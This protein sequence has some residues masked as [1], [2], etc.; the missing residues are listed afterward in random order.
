MLA[1]IAATCAHC[2]AVKGAS[3][4]SGA[5]DIAD[6]DFGDAGDDGIGADSGSAPPPSGNGSNDGGDATVFAGGGK[7]QCSQATLIPLSGANPRVD[8]PSTTVGATHDVD[9]PCAAEQGP[10]IFYRFAV[11]KRAFIYADTFGATWDTVLFLLSDSCVPIPTTMS[12]GATCSDDGCGTKQSQLVALVEPGYYKLGLAG[13]GSATGAA[14]IHFEWALAGSGNVAQ[15][16]KMNSVQVGTTFGSGGNIDGISGDCL[17]AAAENS[18]WWA[19]CPSDPAQTL[20]ASTCAGGTTWE[21][22]LETQIPRSAPAK[23]SAYTCNVN[24]CGLQST[25]T[26]SIPAGAGLGV[27]SIDGQ[28]GN[29][30]GPYTMTVTYTP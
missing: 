21:S 3:G 29:D 14:T 11:S 30:V 9:A 7:D 20:N 23:P 27:L 22:V 12:G 1:L 4:G 26:T 18:Y 16:P 28:G 17:A 2:G 6:I 19:R 13:R 25:L 5:S 8:L 15:L 10:D 24:G